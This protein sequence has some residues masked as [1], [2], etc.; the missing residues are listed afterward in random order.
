MKMGV[1]VFMAKPFDLNRV[2]LR[3]EQL[4]NA[5]KQQ[6]EKIQLD[7]MIDSTADVKD[8]LLNDDERLMKQVLRVIEDNMSD[9]AFN[10]TQLCAETGIGS[11]RL[12]RMLK[13]KTGLSPVNFIRQIRLKKAAILLQQNKFTVSE[14]MFM[15][16]FSH[17]SYFTKCFTEEF[18]V[19]P[20]EYSD[21]Q[22]AIE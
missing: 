9:S 6:Q 19:S 15:V 8:E 11:K 14:V 2:T 20:K 7:K 10:V 12:L 17:P 18:G 13:K 22:I 4:L 21:A 3:I 5:R 1:D 16:G